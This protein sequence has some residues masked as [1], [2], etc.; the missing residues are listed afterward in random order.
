MPAD[1]QKTSANIDNPV[2]IVISRTFAAPRE[3]LWLAW[4]DPK[5]MAQWWG[6]AGFTTT[7]HAMDFRAG[8]AWRYT[9]H[10]PDG[11]DYHNTLEY[12]EIDPPSRLLYKIGGKV[13][14][15]PVNFRT[16]VTFE[17]LKESTSQTKVTMRSIFPSAAQR[18]YVIENYNAVEGG[19]QHMANLED[20]VHTMAS[21]SKDASV[22]SISHVF[23][24]SREKVWA[25]WTTREHLMRWFGPKG[26]S[27]SHATLDLRPGGSLHYCMSHPAGMELW[28]RWVFVEIQSPGR[29]VFISSL[30]N[31]RGEIAPAPFPGLEEFPPE[32]RTTVTFVE[33]AGIGKGTLVTVESEPVNATAAQIAF[34]AKFHSSMNQGWSGTMV[35]LAE[36]LDASSGGA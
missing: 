15:E 9:M 31:P 34:F 1:P 18:N 6:P 4:T 33:H 19:K 26:A 22:F 14:E 13:G 25:V 24:A 28:G 2:E 11:R 17:S 5:H 23:R 29:L 35:Q 36:Y 16:E 7:T 8:G 32:V 20:Y 30:S 27:L 21:G 3:L 10:G 12:I